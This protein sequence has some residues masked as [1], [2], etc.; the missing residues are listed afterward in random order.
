M[1][2]RKTFSRR[3]SLSISCPHSR[4]RFATGRSGTGCSVS[5]RWRN[6]TRGW[7]GLE[8]RLLR[9]NLESAERAE[10]GRGERG[11]MPS[12]AYIEVCLARPED[13]PV[14]AAV[15]RALFYLTRSFICSTLLP[16]TIFVEVY[17]CHSP[18][19]TRLLPPLNIQNGSFCSPFVLANG[20]VWPWWVCWPANSVPAVAKCRTS[21]TSMFPATVARNIFCP[22]ASRG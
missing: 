20:R 22:Q 9:V 3:T 7:N 14:I 16:I 8:L 1:R 2:T 10:N 13:A 12:A 5:W 11:V 19:W 21:P 4:K 6:S 18:L 15:R 17:A